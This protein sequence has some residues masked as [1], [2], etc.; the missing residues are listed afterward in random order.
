MGSYKEQ[1]KEKMPKAR[2]LY[3]DGLSVGRIAKVLSMSRSTVYRWI[4]TFAEEKE[5]VM[6]VKKK[7]AKRVSIPTPEYGRIEVQSKQEKA[8]AQER[9]KIKSESAEEK[10]ARLEKELREARLRADFYDEMINVA[11]KRFDIQIRKKAGAKQ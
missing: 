4:A 11:E 3:D 1:Q 9:V 6:S 8:A 10:I 5:I 7:S 2:I